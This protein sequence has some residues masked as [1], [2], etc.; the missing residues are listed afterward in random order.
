MKHQ[1]TIEQNVIKYIKRHNLLFGAKKILI[2][3]SG[4]ADSIF[5]LHFFYKYSKKYKINILA[6]HINHNLRGKESDKDEVFCKELCRDFNVEFYSANVDVKQ[7]AK[8]KKF[9]IEEAARILRYNELQRIATETK[10]D[11]IVTAHNIND[12]TETVLLNIVS[13]AGIDGISGIPIKRGNIIRPFL[14]ISK[15]EIKDYLNTLNIKYRED[16]SNKNLEFRRNYLRKKIIPLL[17]KEINPSL[18]KVILSST[19]VIRNQKE[20][21]E[22]FISSITNEVISQDKTNVIIKTSKLKDYPEAVLGEIFKFVFQEIINVEYS[23]N[24]FLKL[25]ELISSQTGTN[26]SLTKGF[27][28]LRERNKIIIY[29]PESKKFNKIA[30]SIGE[31]AKLN[32]KKIVIKKLKGIPKKLIKK[33]N[34][35][36]ISADKIKGKLTIRKWKAG[37]KIQPL[38]MKGN[39]KISDILTDQKVPSNKRANQFVL[40]NGNEIIWLIGLKLNDKYKITSKTKSVIKLCLK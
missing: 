37:D 23:F 5:A 7:L 21:L 28:A 2:A 1:K 14:C 40:L 9:S 3:L 22:Y 39:K 17:K 31:T 27:S 34:T 33:N 19:E 36:I 12:N 30:I 32:D 24:N 11:A 26:I 20:V 8:S 38:G 15:E 18:D 13:G 10:S 4:G 35:E 25:K 6:V 29:K 16:S